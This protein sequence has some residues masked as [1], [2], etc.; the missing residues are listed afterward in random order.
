METIWN[1]REKDNSKLVLT[2]KIEVRI[3]EI[4]KALREYRKNNNNR[5]AQWIMFLN[6]PNDEEV[7]KVMEKN[8]EIKKATVEVIKMTEDEKLERLAW[9]REKAILDEYDIEAAGVDKGEKKAK[10]SIAKKMK[11]E[12]IPIDVIVKITNLTKKEIE[13]L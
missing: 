3:I 6:N 5:K 4:R 2:N 11:E 1:L 12:K 9:L 13:E 7:K 10:L 8:K